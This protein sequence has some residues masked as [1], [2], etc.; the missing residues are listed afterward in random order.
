MLFLSRKGIAVLGCL[1]A[2]FARLLYD[3]SDRKYDLNIQNVRIVIA[4]GILLFTSRFFYARSSTSTPR[5]HTHTHTHERTHVNTNIY[6]K[7]I[8]SGLSPRDGI[9]H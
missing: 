6:T 4:S 2:Q 1:F 9:Q 3:M 8:F 7:M 5:T